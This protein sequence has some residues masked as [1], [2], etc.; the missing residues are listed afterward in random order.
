MKASME[1]DD[2]CLTL[3]KIEVSGG[4]ISLVV[5]FS[6]SLTGASSH[7]AL[8]S[9]GSCLKEN[10]TQESLVGNLVWAMTKSKKWWPGEVVGY[11][12]DAKESSFMVRYLGEGQLE[13]WC[14]PSKLRPFKES[15]ERLA[16][17]RNDVGFFVAV[18][19]AMTLLRNSLKLEMT[20]S[21]MSER[22][23]KKPARKTK[24]LILRDFS[25]DRLEPKE[26]VTRLKNLAECVS[27]GGILEATV[28][29]SRLSA[30]YSFCGHK[31]IPMDQLN[32]NEARRSFNG[33]KMEE[34]EFVGSPSV[35]AGSRRR[36]FRKEWFRKFVSEVD[37]V[38][39]REDLVDTSP[40]DLVSKLKLLAVD[41]ST[42][43]E[44][45]ENVGLFE[46]FFS[47]FRISVFHDENS[48]RMQLANMAGL[49][50]LMVAK[51]ANPGTE[52]RTSK[53]KN[54]GKSKIE[55]FCG[56]SVAGAE[57]KTFESQKI[58]EK[59][60]IELI[61]CVSVSDTEQ[62]ISESHEN[63]ERSK[64]EVIGGVSVA[65]TEQ[66]TFELQK[67]SE[68]SKIEVV[69]GVSVADA[70]QKAN[71]RAEK[72]R[73]YHRASKPKMPG[74]KTIKDTISRSDFSSSVANE[75]SLQGKACMADTLSRP[76]A[77]LVPD[78]NSGG[79]ALAS[80]ESDHLQ[81]PE[82][83]VPPS[84]LPQKEERPFSV[85]LNFQAAAA[86]AAAAAAPRSIYGASGTGYVSSLTDLERRF[87]S[88]DLCAKVTG[89]EK[90][91]RG[92]KRKNPEAAHATNGIPDLNG[93]TKEPASVPPQ[94]EPTLRR[95]RR[96]KEEMPN[97]STR[98]ITVLVLKFSSKELMP[99]KDDLTS[100]FSAF[101]P[102][103][104]SETH[105]YEELS[106]AEVAFVSS[107]DAVEA[108]KSLDKANPFGENLVSFRLQQKLINVVYRNIAPRMPAISH[109]SPLQKPKNPPI[110][111]ESMKQNLL[112]MT[113]ML[114]KSGD[115]LS[116]ETKAKLKSDISALLEKI[117]SMPSSSSSSS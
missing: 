69:G 53:S 87:T 32:Q 67:N 111:V 117:S 73:T 2:E 54:V 34:S 7:N 51:A 79:N 28:M 3:R 19:E 70:D 33:S 43:S 76:S 5:D 61:G 56:V 55:P 9:N 101:G 63:S 91:K 68:K 113:A 29:Q 107:G 39:A 81:K 78:L 16:S 85:M 40:S 49:N 75:P 45:T 115:H 30:F 109:V 104:A 1:E 38:S 20:C 74:L 72:Y 37:N 11:K 25:V 48:Y 108:V 112:M 17:Q 4:N 105:V 97:R 84:P 98:G 88:A 44:E 24:P 95:K 8:E 59:S 66:K 18:E 116:R 62:K 35:V 23:G 13:S 77:T 89:T 90:K 100:T 65:N 94:A 103:D 114:D 10:Q 80:A 93:T 26:F 71:I 41:S 99:S 36:K 6:G 110:S 96:K 82:T 86:A 64:M 50:D 92:R 14:A 15:F 58:P 12:A 42:C 21:C 52:L 27:S 46:W 22:N 83:L 106:G 57:Q 31:Q 60:K 102:L 47:K